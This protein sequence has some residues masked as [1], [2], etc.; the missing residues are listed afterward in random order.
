MMLASRAASMGP[1]L[2]PR[3]VS[4]SKDVAVSERDVGVVT[5]ELKMERLVAA[6]EKAALG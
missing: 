4:R 3:Y 2:D 1:F 6:G 5:G